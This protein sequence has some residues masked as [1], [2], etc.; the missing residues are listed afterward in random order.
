MMKTT[1]VFLLMVTACCGAAVAVDAGI[2]IIPKTEDDYG[3][4][5]RLFKEENIP[6][7]TSLCPL[8][9][10]SMRLSEVSQ[11]QP[12]NRRLKINDGLTA[13]NLTSTNDECTNEEGLT[14]VIQKKK[15]N[16]TDQFPLLPT[17]ATIKP[18]TKN[19]PMSSSTIQ[20]SS[21]ANVAI[22]LPSSPR[23]AAS[24]TSG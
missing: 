10:T 21:Q 24:E 4:I 17:E 13:T 8:N 20:P 19:S 12:P 11:H 15:R 3:R 16:V 1:L 6:H 23:T 2:R 18:T 22:A 7:H 9:A 14:P 5:I